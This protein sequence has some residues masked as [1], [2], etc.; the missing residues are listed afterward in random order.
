MN[1]NDSFNTSD[2]NRVPLHD[3][4]LSSYSSSSRSWKC[5][6][7][8]KLFLLASCSNLDEFN[9]FR[10]LKGSGHRHR[11]ARM[12]PIVTPKTK[13][14]EIQSGINSWQ[15][16]NSESGLSYDYRDRRVER[17]SNMFKPL[18][19]SDVYYCLVI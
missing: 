5:S 8:S 10:V 16:Q 1:S 17:H 9:K 4:N 7:N 15:N 6:T 18:G 2:T 12:I 14:H 13:Q 3:H 19:I 11:M